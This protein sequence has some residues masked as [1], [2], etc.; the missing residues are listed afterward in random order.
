MSRSAGETAMP[1][2]PMSP[3]GSPVVARRHVRPPSV[4]LW[5]PDPGPPASSAHT[6]RRLSYVAAYMTSGSTGS[7]SMSVTPVFSSTVRTA[8]QVSPPSSVR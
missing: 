1:I 5:I 7:N 3:L 4:D 8:S 2:L 6:L